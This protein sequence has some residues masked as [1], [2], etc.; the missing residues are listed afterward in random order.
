MDDLSKHETAETAAIVIL[1]N[2]PIRHPL[3]CLSMMHDLARHLFMRFRL[4]EAE[5]LKGVISK[6]NRVW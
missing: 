5:I 2:D 6:E 1:S 4:D 3:I